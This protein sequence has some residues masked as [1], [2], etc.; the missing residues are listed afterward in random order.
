MGAQ[1]MGKHTEKQI[2]W[3]RSKAEK[4]LQRKC[5]GVLSN[6]EKRSKGVN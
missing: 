1:H 2:I 5:I 4:H 6:Q 3:D